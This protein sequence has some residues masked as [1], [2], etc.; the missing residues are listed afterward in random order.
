MKIIGVTGGIGAGKTSVST[1]LEKLGAIVIDADKLSKDA[2]ERGKPAYERII[3]EFGP[4]I[5][6]NDLNIDR[7]ILGQI[8]FNNPE[9]RLKLEEIV[10]AE[11]VNSILNKINDL[12]SKGYNGVLVL[13]VPIP[14]EHGFLDTVDQV[15]VVTASENTR[16]NR[17]QK[18]SGLSREEVIKRMR[19][20]IS[21][22]DYISLADVVVDNDGTLESLKQKVENLF[23]H[24]ITCISE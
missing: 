13:D 1:I 22:D 19:S 16:I 20:Q 9:K 21:Q 23:C 12:R 15:W 11:V 18:R 2:V 8:V 17:V 5:L 6:D 7:K 4:D 10:H 3:K 14:V 24:F